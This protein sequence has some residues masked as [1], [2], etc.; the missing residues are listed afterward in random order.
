M[1]LPRPSYI[2]DI[3]IAY[4]E[5]L[6]KTSGAYIMIEIDEEGLMRKI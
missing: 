2:L 6:Y 1:Y 5:I 4:D 3:K